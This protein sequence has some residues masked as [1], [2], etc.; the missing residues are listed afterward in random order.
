MKR[1]ELT[2]LLLRE[3][4]QRVRNTI[5]HAKEADKKRTYYE[6]LE[7]LPDF[8]HNA[9]YDKGAPYMDYLLGNLPGLDISVKSRVYDFIQTYDTS[10]FEEIYVDIGERFCYDP[11]YMIPLELVLIRQQC[12]KNLRVTVI[13]LTSAMAYRNNNDSILNSGNVTLT[14]YILP[15]GSVLT[16]ER[17]NT[18]RKKLDCYEETKEN[19]EFDIF[20]RGDLVVL[21][22]ALDSLERLI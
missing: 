2:G 17:I 1:N 20:Y 6:L 7:M 15:D 8:I 19:N 10:R 13:S 14:D 4:S 5:T 9:V 16:P 12:K 21:R 11:I 22:D 18:A 3:M